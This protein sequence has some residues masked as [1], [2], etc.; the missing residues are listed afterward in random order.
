MSLTRSALRPIARLAV[1]QNSYPASGPLYIYASCAEFS[2][3]P[4][5]NK[6]RVTATRSSRN[7]IVETEAVDPWVEVKDE[8]SGQIY[9]W[10]TVTDE[11]TAIG[12]PKPSAI[13]SGPPGPAPAPHEGGGGMMSGLGGVVAQGFAFG[14][15]SSVAHGLVGS[16]F[17]GGD[18]GGGGDGGGGDDGFDI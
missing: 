11:T 9:Y 18:D 12:E 15:G 7:S 5:S 8:H 13:R 16:M 4:K 3:F 1:K 14:V 17:G 2:R 6:R 10:N